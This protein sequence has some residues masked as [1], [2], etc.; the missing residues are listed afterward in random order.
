MVCPETLISLPHKL[1]IERKNE[2]KKYNDICKKTYEN[3]KVTY[4][5]TP[6]WFEI[7][8]ETNSMV[9]HRLYRADDSFYKPV[10]G[11]RSKISH[12]YEIL[13]SFF[14]NYKVVPAWIES[15]SGGYYDN[16]NGNWTG[17]VGKVL[18]I[19]L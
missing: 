10:V 6:W 17:A 11:E 16:E 2:N 14:K 7:D 19:L 9:D 3:S 13:S 8:K 4:I 1:L 18:P 15:F 5:N 12:D